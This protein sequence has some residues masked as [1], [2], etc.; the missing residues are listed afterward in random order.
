VVRFETTTPS[1]STAGQWTAAYLPEGTTASGTTLTPGNLR[2]LQDSV[3][4]M[5]QVVNS[6]ITNNSTLESGY[7]GVLLIPGDTNPRV[8]KVSK[9][10]LAM[11]LSP[12]YFC[13]GT[14][15]AGVTQGVLSFA[16]GD[17]AGGNTVVFT[18]VLRWKITFFEAIDSATLGK[19]E[20]PPVLSSNPVVSAT[21]KQRARCPDDDEKSDDGVLVKPFKKR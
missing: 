7:P 21:V 17:T 8:L 19:P 13:Q 10:S 1:T 4:G 6:N 3:S 14:S 12:M 18:C 9:A 2:T 15:G 20:L 11:G 5:A 16:L